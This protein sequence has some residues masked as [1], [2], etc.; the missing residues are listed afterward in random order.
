[1]IRCFIGHSK[2]TIETEITKLATE[3]EAIADLNRVALD[4]DA[5]DMET[6]QVHCDTMPFLGGAKLVIVRGYAE[7]LSQ[8]EAPAR[9]AP[10]VFAAR[11][12]A[13]HP[14]FGG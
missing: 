1:M 11:A 6:L 9:R 14:G 8:R 5:I 3:G 4:G 10:S 7:S 2:G 13:L 12:R